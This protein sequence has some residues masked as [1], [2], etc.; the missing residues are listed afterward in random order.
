MANITSRATW[1]AAAFTA[2]AVG[3]AGAVDLIDSGDVK[4]GSLKVKDLSKKARQQLK[5][6]RGPRGLQGPAGPTGLPGVNGT[7][8]INGQNGV[9]GVDG[10]PG[11]DGAT[12]APGVAGPVL[13][14]MAWL[15][16]T[17]YYSLFLNTTDTT[18]PI[19]TDTTETIV[20]EPVPPPGLTARR[21]GVVLE[22]KGFAATTVTLRAG[23]SASQADT[24]LSCIVPIDQTTCEDVDTDDLPAGTYVSL[25][26]SSVSKVPGTAFVRLEPKG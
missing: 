19:G 22:S 1:A 8:G 25:A 21:L 12:G 9:D 17:T 13:V 15:S 26:M 18:F 24:T 4:D 16:T 20:N 14:K 10:A 11:A 6:N 23:P 3:T 7:N 5:G 2:G